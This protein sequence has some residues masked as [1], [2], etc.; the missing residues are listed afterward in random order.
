MKFKP[1]IVDGIPTHWTAA[2]VARAANEAVVYENYA[3]WICRE[4]VFMTDDLNMDNSSWNLRPSILLPP[5][6]YK[7]CDLYSDNDMG[8]SLADFLNGAL[9]DGI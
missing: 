3:I 4:T 9:E 2:D 5:N 1:L 7:L 6:L 8:M